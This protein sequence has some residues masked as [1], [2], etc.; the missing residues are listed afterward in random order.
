M[1][2]SPGREAWVT[3]K[4]VLCQSPARRA[5][6]REAFGSVLQHVRQLC[7]DFSTQTSLPTRSIQVLWMPLPSP[8]GLGVE[9]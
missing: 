8:T 3:D 1:I 7:L 9:D 2:R 4:E 5:E 6:V